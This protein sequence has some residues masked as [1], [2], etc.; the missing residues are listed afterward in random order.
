[1]GARVAVERRIG[2]AAGDDFREFARRGLAF[3][4]ESVADFHGLVVDSAARGR[5]RGE[6]SHAPTPRRS[7]RSIRSPEAGDFGLLCDRIVLRGR[8]CVA[9][10]ALLV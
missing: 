6:D 10:R 5:A 9:G 8:D 1:M 2:P 7:F 4:I 3:G